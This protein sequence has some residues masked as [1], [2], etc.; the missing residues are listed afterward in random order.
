MRFTGFLISISTNNMTK[1]SFVRF[2]IFSSMGGHFPRGL[3]PSYKKAI[4]PSF[5]IAS[6]EH[7]ST[8]ERSLNGNLAPVVTKF[9]R[10]LKEPTTT[11]MQGHSFGSG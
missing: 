10:S 9:N 11:K 2:S 1:R 3:R 7:Y 4:Y 8:S 5:P 6:R